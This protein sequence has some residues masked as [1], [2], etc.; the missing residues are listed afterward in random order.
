MCVVLCGAAA[1]G[2]ADRAAAQR[3]VKP[4]DICPPSV[5][6]LPSPLEGRRL[7][8]GFT[9]R[10]AT[11]FV[12][13]TEA[14]ALFLTGRVRRPVEYSLRG[15]V[16]IAR[17]PEH[18]RAWLDCLHAYSPRF[19]EFGE[20]G[21][22]GSAVTAESVG[23]ILRGPRSAALARHLGVDVLGGVLSCRASL[24]HSDSHGLERRYLVGFG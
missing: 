18:F 1:R 21:E 16:V 5:Y 11:H 24:S 3:V 14:G 4:A 2:C 19:M 23:E 7:Q 17:Y 9:Y 10:R 13:V 8:D 20:S 15:V 6:D 12:R 22:G